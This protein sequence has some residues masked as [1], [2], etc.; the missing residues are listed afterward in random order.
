MKHLVDIEFIAHPRM[1]G[2]DCIKC[3]DLPLAYSYVP[4]Q[5]YETPYGK[6]KAF[7]AGTIFPGLNKP[8][9]IYGKEFSSKAG[10]K[11]I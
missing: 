5:T 2:D 4:Y 3:N 11:E 9:G 6:N 1:A 10:A 8:Y 7:F